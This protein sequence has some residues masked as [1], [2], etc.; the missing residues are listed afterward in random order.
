MN[1]VPP[2]GALA[3]WNLSPTASAVGYVLSSLAGLA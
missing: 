1:L 3:S 2:S